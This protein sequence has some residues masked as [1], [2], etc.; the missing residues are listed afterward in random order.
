MV[1]GYLG[2]SRSRNILEEN[3]EK[4][5]DTILSTSRSRLARSPPRPPPASQSA[6]RAASPP[7]APPSPGTAPRTPPSTTSPSDPVIK[8]P[9]EPKISLSENP[10]Q[11]KSQSLPAPQSTT[12]ATRPP[13]ASS[14]P[15]T[16]P[17]IPPSPTSPPDPVI[18]ELPEPEISAS[19]TPNQT[20]IRS[21]PNRSSL[22]HCPPDGGGR[23][24]A[25][26][27]QPSQQ[28]RDPASR[29]P[30]SPP[31]WT[32]TGCL[33]LANS[34]A[35]RAA[36]LSRNSTT[37]KTGS[38][39]DIKARMRTTLFPRGE[40]QTLPSTNE[41]KPDLKPR[42]HRSNELESKLQASSTNQHNSGG[43]GHYNNNNST[44]KS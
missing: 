34:E 24:E 27:G 41:P 21:L 35:R 18:R 17:R 37:N 12:G 38:E 6:T 19:E 3:N 15:G 31:S 16:A 26:Q 22:P 13:R 1:H 39:D 23:G 11:P 14:S 8:E 2:E 40:G 28:P 4:N 20:R 30:R 43:Y 9:P 29:K 44:T 36:T 10:A 42:L 32:L 25:T 5:Y 33:S 7:R